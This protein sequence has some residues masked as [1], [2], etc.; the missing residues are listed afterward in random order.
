MLSDSQKLSEK[1]S[2]VVIKLTH[3]QDAKNSLPEV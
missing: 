1:G 2:I 3:R